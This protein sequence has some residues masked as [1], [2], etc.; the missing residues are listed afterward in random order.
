VRHFK[1]SSNATGKLKNVQ[2][3]MNLPPLKV[4]QD[5]PTRWNSGLIMM[6]RLI[7]I[8]SPLR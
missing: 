8:K 2:F 1:H 3:Q 5:M 7:N 6:G 4:K